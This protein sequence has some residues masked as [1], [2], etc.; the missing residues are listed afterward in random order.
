VEEILLT[1]IAAV[2][3]EAESWNDIADYGGGKKEGWQQLRYQ[4]SS[5]RYIQ[6]RMRSSQL[7]EAHV[8]R[9]RY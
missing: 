3:N 6:A 5:Q 8:V 2:M 4:P 9:Q 1:A 7:P